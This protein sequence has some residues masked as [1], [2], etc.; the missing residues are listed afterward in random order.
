MSVIFFFAGNLAAVRIIGVSVI[1]RCPQGESYCTES[2]FMLMFRYLLQ[3]KVFSLPV[4][5]QPVQEALNHFIA[6]LSRAEEVAASHPPLKADLISLKEEE[7]A[8]T[9]CCT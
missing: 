3:E 2:C 5:H 4:D 8:H 7:I 6:W 9:V 1:A